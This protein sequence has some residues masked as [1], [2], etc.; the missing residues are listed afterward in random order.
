MSTLP[1]ST[2]VNL[3]SSRGPVPPR[4]LSL[5]MSQRANCGNG[6]SAGE[7]LTGHV[8]RESSG[9]QPGVLNRMVNGLQQWSN[10]RG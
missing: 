7:I 10:S 4:S 6:N 2:I 5:L 3:D 9:L 1:C 8:L